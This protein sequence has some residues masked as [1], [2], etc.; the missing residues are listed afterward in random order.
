[1]NAEY[2]GPA[3]IK[4]TAEFPQSGL[5]DVHGDFSVEAI[6][7]GGVRMLISGKFPNGIRFEGSEGWI[8]VTRGDYS[9][10]A[11]DPTGGNDA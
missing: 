9:V 11:S 3:E 1:M 4:A 5:W 6:Y 8:F 10:T 7:P 2:S